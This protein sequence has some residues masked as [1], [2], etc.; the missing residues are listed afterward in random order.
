MINFV[1]D[2]RGKPAVAVSEVIEVS[3]VFRWDA[4]NPEH[5]DIAVEEY[6]FKAYLR[7]GKKV[8]YA[9]D[10]QHQAR[11]QRAILIR[12]I[13]KY[14]SLK[15]NAAQIISKAITELQHKIP[16]DVTRQLDKRIRSMTAGRFG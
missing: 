13:D 16:A 3:A 15:D 14:S 11:N 4:Y 1:F 9:F 8:F 2:P 6:V 7:N 5:P 10:S 12:K